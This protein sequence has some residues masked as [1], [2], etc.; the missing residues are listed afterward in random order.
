MLP[1]PSSYANINNKYGGWPYN[2]EID[3]MEA[4][5]RLLN[6]VD[7]TL[8]YGPINEGT[9]QSK[10]DTTE[11]TLTS[12]TDE[13]HIYAV[14]W[15]A[16]YIKWFVDGKAVQTISSST[17]YTLSSSDASAPFDQPFYILLNLAVGGSYDPQGSV[18]SNFTSAS[19]YVDYVRVY[20]AL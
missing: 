2:G 14:E 6:K 11:T 1:Q 17:W 20:E 16:N 7:T 4:K 13:W 10:Y 12:N 3:I 15:T 9:W 18:P 5:G 8:H 19:M